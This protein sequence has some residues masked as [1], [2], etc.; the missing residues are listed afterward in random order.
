[1]QDFKHKRKYYSDQE[2]L[3]GINKYQFMYNFNDVLFSREKSL[4]KTRFNNYWKN[5]RV[6][7]KR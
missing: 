6:D 4:P 7:K 1:M 3:I 5:F 2:T